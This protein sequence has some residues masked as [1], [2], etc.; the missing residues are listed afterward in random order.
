[1]P[2]TNQETFD[3]HEAPLGVYLMQ[4]YERYCNTIVNNNTM[5]LAI[6][7]MYLFFPL[8][9][10]DAIRNQKLFIKDLQTKRKKVVAQILPRLIDIFTFEHNKNKLQ[11]KNNRK[12]KACRFKKR[13]VTKHTVVRIVGRQFKRGRIRYLFR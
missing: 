7:Y 4:G 12:K 9:I 6:T 10:V 3:R 8:M 11:K 5:I 1:M 13:K 2:K